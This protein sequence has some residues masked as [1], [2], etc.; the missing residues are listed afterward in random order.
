M[1]EPVRRLLLRRDGE[2]VDETTVC[3]GSFGSYA[4][5]RQRNEASGG[6]G[7]IARS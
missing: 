6:D 3:C 1:W 5:M 4:R 7:A 2:A